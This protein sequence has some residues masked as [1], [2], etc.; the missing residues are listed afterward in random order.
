MFSKPAVI[1][2]VVANLVS[3]RGS[4]LPLAARNQLGKRDSIQ[5]GIPLECG[6]AKHGFVES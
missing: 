3:A 5:A 1:L 2:A 6:G 4:S